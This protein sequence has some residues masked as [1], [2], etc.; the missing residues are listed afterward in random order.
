M[1]DIGSPTSAYTTSAAT[2]NYSLTS[3]RGQAI[4]YGLA[5]RSLGAKSVSHRAG[6]P[7]MSMMQP[8]GR[9]SS[10]STRQPLQ[11]GTSNILSRLA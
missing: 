2:R 9:R 5:Q 6:I 4:M 3:K 1:P 8:D 7:E 10:V 11:G